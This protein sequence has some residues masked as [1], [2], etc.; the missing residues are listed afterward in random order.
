MAHIKWF[1]IVVSIFISLMSNQVKGM[2]SNWFLVLSLNIYLQMKGYIYASNL[3]LSYTDKA[4][5]FLAS[6]I[7]LKK[8]IKLSQ[9]CWMFINW[10][11]CFSLF[12]R[13]IYRTFQK[14]IY[15]R[16]AIKTFCRTIKTL[17]I[18][19]YCTWYYSLSSLMT[20]SAFFSLAV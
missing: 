14:Q 12:F 13:E 15:L 9:K 18:L 8:K 16:I 20:Y 1:H 11:L 5:D 19:C 7:K 6:E 2:E 17:I 3:Y 10:D 4:S